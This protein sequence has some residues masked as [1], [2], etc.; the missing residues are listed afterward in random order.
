MAKWGLLNHHREPPSFHERRGIRNI[1]LQRGA[2]P[3]SWTLASEPLR[4]AGSRTPPG[5]PRQPQ[6]SGALWWPCASVPKKTSANRKRPV[7]WLLAVKKGLLKLWDRT[8]GP[9]RR[10]APRASVAGTP[11]SPGSSLKPEGTWWHLPHLTDE[12]TVTCPRSQTP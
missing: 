6:A 9:K 1:K 3:V 11:S 2:H 10:A 12:D 7:S 4:F 8:P 5:L